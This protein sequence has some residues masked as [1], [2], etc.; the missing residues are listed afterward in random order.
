MYDSTHW[1]VSNRTTY[2]AETHAGGIKQAI[3]Q[4]TDAG[5]AAKTLLSIPAQKIPRQNPDGLHL[6]DCRTNLPA[7]LH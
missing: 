1:P 4:Q 6:S 7:T 5:K 2:H 3:P